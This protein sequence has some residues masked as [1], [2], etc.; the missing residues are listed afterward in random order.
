MS[1]PLHPSPCPA[2]PWPWWT[3]DAPRKVHL[4]QSPLLAP[5][6]A[7]EARD[8]ITGPPT[9][10][11]AHTTPHIVA[12]GKLSGPWKLPPR[13]IHSPGLGLG[14]QGL[15]K[16]WEKAGTH[17]DKRCG[18]GATDWEWELKE[19]GFSRLGEG[20]LAT[21]SPKQWP[22]SHGPAEQAMGKSADRTCSHPDSADNPYRP[23]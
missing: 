12:V 1:S 17:S 4:A 16:P 7:F 11:Q 14:V 15:A 22:L 9:L 19:L 21:A 3:P 23:R 6:L 18:K 13:P 5:G 20:G 8:L 2:L 10:T